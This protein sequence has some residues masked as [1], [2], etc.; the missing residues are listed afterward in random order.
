M[1]QPFVIIP[2]SQAGVP[3][4]A[5]DYAQWLTIVESAAQSEGPREQ[6]PYI[7]DVTIPGGNRSYYVL[8]AAQKKGLTRG[9]WAGTCHKLSLNEIVRISELALATPYTTDATPHPLGKQE[10]IQLCNALV[11][12]A[13]KAEANDSSGCAEAARK[14]SHK[15]RHLF[16]NPKPILP[17]KSSRYARRAAFTLRVLFPN[18]KPQYLIDPEGIPCPI[19]TTLDKIN[20]FI[21]KLITSPKFQIGLQVLLVATATT[22]SI[23]TG[24]W[25]CIAIVMTALIVQKIVAKALGS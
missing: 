18:A 25:E 22:V 3:P 16:T 21:K 5:F 14:I 1:T 23:I 10:K 17:P 7:Y 20:T 9:N 8:N 24:Q 6:R 4:F 13:V 15:V 12:M 19:Q 11:S 2:I